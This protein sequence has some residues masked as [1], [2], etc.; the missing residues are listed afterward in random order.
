MGAL[1]TG[2]LLK[3]KSWVTLEDAASHLSLVLEE[4]VNEGDLIQ[5]ALERKLTLSVVFPESA[6]IVLY[7][8]ADVSRESLPMQEFKDYDT[9]VDPISILMNDRRQIWRHYTFHTN[10]CRVQ[11]PNF[12][13]CYSVSGIHYLLISPTS[14]RILRQLLQASLSKPL[15][16]PPRWPGKPIML[17]DSE[18]RGPV[19]LVN[20]AAEYEG[21]APAWI[22][23]FKPVTTLPESASLVVSRD[24]LAQFT[25]SLLSSEADTNQSALPATTNDDSEFARL[26]RTVAALALGL[27]REYPKYR[28]GDKPNISKLTDLATDHLRSEHGDRPPHGFGKSTRSD[29]IK[30]ALERY[31]DLN[32]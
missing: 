19:G 8:D 17:T 4:K 29:A 14:E 22:D 10:G 26:E 5:L 1:M 28:Y 3:L 20:F 31:R 27:M 13:S 32:E 9:P 6:H 30:A 24:M 23:R 2:K 7:E 21:E 15:L 11:E 25:A 12:D 16:S 18:L